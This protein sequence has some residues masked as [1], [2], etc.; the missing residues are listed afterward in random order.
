MKSLWENQAI[1]K[2]TA[3]V[4]PVW[5]ILTSFQCL[6]RLQLRSLLP[7]LNIRSIPVERFFSWFAYSRWNGLKTNKWLSPFRCRLICG[8]FSAA[9]NWRERSKMCSNPNRGPLFFRAK[10]NTT[11][12]L[13]YFVQAHAY[14]TLSFVAT[15]WVYRL[16]KKSL[17]L[18][19]V[20]RVSDWMI[21]YM[22]TVTNTSCSLHQRESSKVPDASSCKMTKWTVH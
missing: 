15:N 9:P 16:K 19:D 17:I 10:S 6:S 20:S 13:L 2:K 14:Q 7:E 11:S 8:I 4:G 12:R 1:K 5:I 18:F 21:M 3:P 22:H